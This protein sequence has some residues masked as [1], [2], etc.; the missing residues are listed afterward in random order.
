MK[1]FADRHTYQQITSALAQLVVSHHGIIP[2]HE[3]LRAVELAERLLDDQ[4]MMN[5]AAGNPM[6]ESERPH[7]TIPLKRPETV[8]SGTAGATPCRDM[9]L[10]CKCQNDGL[11]AQGGGDN[12]G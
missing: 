12:A 4:R 1:S 6:S 7:V 5:W 10:P 2:A 3:R 8:N 11:Q 9:G